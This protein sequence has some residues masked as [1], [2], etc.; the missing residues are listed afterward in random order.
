VPHASCRLQWLPVPLS[1]SSSKWRNLAVLTAAC[2]LER[3][4]L[5]SRIILGRFAGDIGRRLAGAAE[6]NGVLRQ[7]SR[8]DAEVE[9]A[10]A[11]YARTAPGTRGSGNSPR[12]AA[13][14]RIEDGA[15]VSGDH[16]SAGQSSPPMT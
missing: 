13:A 11:R 8:V 2:M 1:T 15:A 5:A 10:V 6:R 14:R 12:L 16:Q 7:A 4:S 3:R 9:I